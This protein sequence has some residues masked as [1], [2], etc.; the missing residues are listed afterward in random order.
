[1]YQEGYEVGS[2]LDESELS[3]RVPPISHRGLMVNACSGWEQQFTVHRTN[4][5]IKLETDSWEIVV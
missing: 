5:G 3:L 4:S 2:R 1:M